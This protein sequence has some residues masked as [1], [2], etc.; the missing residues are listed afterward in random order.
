L[1]PST[2]STRHVSRRSVTCS[3]AG[4]PRGGS[5]CGRA[6]ATDCSQDSGFTMMLLLLL[7]LLLLVLWLLLAAR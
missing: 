3:T 5:G 6:S 7:L 4:A 1:K 2:L